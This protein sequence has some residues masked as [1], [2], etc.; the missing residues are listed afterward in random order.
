MSQKTIL[1]PEQNRAADPTVNVW[2]QANAGTG[3]TSVLVQR[4]LR[5]LFRSGLDAQKSTPGG[6]LCLTYTNA[7]AAEMRNRI[8]GS[9]RSWAYADDD[10]LRDLL[11]GISH[12]NPPTNDDLAHARRL[13]YNYIDDANMLKVRTIHSFCEEVLHRFP[14]EAGISPSWHLV[15]DADQK[16]LMNAAFTE[17]INSNAAPKVKWAFD[18]IVGRISE[19]AFDQLLGVL[20]E[21]YRTMFQMNKNFNYQEQFIDTI[22]NYLKIDPRDESNFFAQNAIQNRRDIGARIAAE[23]KPTKTLLANADALKKY[24]GGEINFDEYK[25]IYLTADGV[26]RKKLKEYM[27][28]EQELVRAFDQFQRDK[29][30][31]DDTLALFYLS[32]AFAK[33]YGELKMSRNSLDFDDIILYTARLFSDPA[34]MG[35]VLS[36]LDSN[37]A[38]ILV[39]EAQDTSPEQWGILKALATNFFTN[40]DSSDNPRSLFVVGDLKQS[41]YSFQGASPDEFAATK[42]IIAKQL[43]TDKRDIAEIPLSRSFRSVAA[44]LSVVDYFFDDVSIRSMAKFKNNIHK[45]F[46]TGDAG[47]VELHPLNA[48]A[49]DEDPDTVPDQNGAFS[50]GKGTDAPD[51]ARLENTAARRRAYL[52]EIADKVNELITH[53]T[54]ESAGRP[55]VAHDIMIL[56]QKRTPFAAPLVA[57]LKSRGIAVAGSDRIKL[58]RFPA[59]RDLLNLGRFCLDPANDYALACTLKSPLFRLSEGD[60]FESAY[61]RGEI[62]LFNRVNALFPDVY[63]QLQ[64]ILIWSLM[65]P[66]TFFMQV[67]N[68]DGRRE[69]IIAAMGAQIIDPLEEFLTI[70]LSYERTQT[71]GLREFMRWFM[72]GGSEIKRDMETGAGVRIMTVHAAKGLDAPIVFLIDTIEN[73]KSKRDGVGRMVPL[74]G[75][76]YLWSPDGALSDKFKAAAQDKLQTQVE[77]Y[78]RLLYV[79][80]TRA[81]DRLYIYGFGMTKNPPELAWHTTLAGILPTHPDAATDAKGVIRISCPQTREIVSAPI[82]PAAGV[83]KTTRI[84]PKIKPSPPSGDLEKF[85]HT[86][87][88]DLD[89]FFAAQKSRECAT[90]TGT[91]R[92]ARLQKINI[93]DPADALGQKIRSMPELI[94]F[95]AS[96]ARAEVPIAGIIN[97]KFVSRRIDRLTVDHGARTIKFMDY[98]TDVDPAARRDKYDV[99]MREYAALLAAAHAG[100]KIMGYILWTK[101]WTVQRVV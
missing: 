56:V 14:M 36:Q 17:L 69:K 53:E 11:T 100:Y 37:L 3:K 87:P 76:A 64:Q 29:T 47:L 18:R 48:P 5:I 8:L 51:P 61:N 79:A 32:D 39:D 99:Q 46:R 12:H 75:P 23:T 94:E 41:I 26:S 85:D 83:I 57:E 89:A 60:L 91:E 58:P 68:T 84:V 65:P 55:I 52:T 44:I 10:A 66:Y 86:Q 74:D 62:T 42:G 95:F 31:Y 82:A 43:A 49:T 98:K 92:H 38:H 28:S 33:K 35:W 90:K 27:L 96:G 93:N 54:L 7:G 81:R 1:S 71:G 34:K 67:L 25:K 88:R 72:Q 45:C 101:D 80:A 19:Y 30:I 63:N 2:A 6:I 20:T 40:G 50:P 13:F 16:R 22:N 77:E 70:C 15:Q 73:P 9:L 21:Q 24:L 4:L 78:Y 59:I 97:G